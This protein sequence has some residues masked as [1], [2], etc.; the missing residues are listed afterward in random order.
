MHLLTIIVHCDNHIVIGPSQLPC[1]L[2]HACVLLVSLTG[3]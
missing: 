3:P 1:C 2:L